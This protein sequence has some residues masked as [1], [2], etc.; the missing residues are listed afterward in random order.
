M[1][2][3]HMPPK[4]GF[5]VLALAWRD[6]LRCPLCGCF[7]RALQAVLCQGSD[8]STEGANAVPSEMPPQRA[9]R[10]EAELRLLA[11]LWAP[12]S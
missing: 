6:L 10:E 5:T 11:W 9:W 3:K 8:V 7:H 4:L 1:L 12:G 2:F